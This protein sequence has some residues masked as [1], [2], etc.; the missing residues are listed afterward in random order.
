MVDLHGE[1]PPPRSKLKAAARHGAKGEVAPHQETKIG[2]EWSHELKRP[3]K[4]Y[5]DVNREANRY[6]ERVVDP[7][8]G[9][10]L[11]EVDKP[12]TDHVGHGSDKPHDEPSR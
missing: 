5:R 1:L 12:L 2:S 6:R 11:R 9:E 7:V 8:T 10:I 3:V 4:V